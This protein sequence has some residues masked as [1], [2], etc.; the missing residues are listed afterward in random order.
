MHGSRAVV[1]VGGGDK[2][3]GEGPAGSG[4]PAVADREVCRRRYINTAMILPFVP[5]QETPGEQWLSRS[6]TTFS[7][8]RRVEFS[9]DSKQVVV[10]EQMGDELWDVATG[11][12]VLGKRPS[13]SPSFA[14]VRAGGG[15]YRA[16]SWE[17][18]EA[19][20]EPA[21]LATVDLGTWPRPPEGV[22]WYPPAYA[23]TT[24][25]WVCGQ[26]SGT[27]KGSTLTV[28]RDGTTTVRRFEGATRAL[29]GLSKDGART[30]A[31]VVDAAGKAELVDLA[32]GKRRRAVPEN[33]AAEAVALV[34][35]DDGERALVET[36]Q[37]G[38]GYYVD[39]SQPEAAPVRYVGVVAGSFS[40][41]LRT[42]AVYLPMVGASANPANYKVW[43]RT[44]PGAASDDALGQ[45]RLLV[46]R[47]ATTLAPDTLEKVAAPLRA[48][49]AELDGIDGEVSA[50]MTKAG[51]EFVAKRV[52]TTV[53]DARDGATRGRTAVEFDVE[54]GSYTVM[55]LVEREVPSL[56]FAVHRFTG[57]VSTR[58]LAA[59]E[60]RVEG[61]RTYAMAAFTAQ[62][63]NALRVV[64][65]GP[66]GMAYRALLFRKR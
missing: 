41:N 25:S 12:K 23:P 63:K 34:V 61:G 54:P 17:P 27:G 62:R 56:T 65:P 55:V 2:K 48:K 50:A 3:V 14:V 8:V 28:T 19:G 22:I 60:A 35:S 5:P 11:E 21:T 42:A 66:Q 7:P 47:L 46:D 18:V 33:V 31:L 57:E 45:G 1:G 43:L 29:A 30:M 20:R 15:V 10:T 51:Q 9:M 36:R 58:L 53:G 6:M 13:T 52:G 4:R 40:P 32:D 38:T 44:M 26:I 49:S 24:K 39:L 16:T 64:I 59:D 37:Q